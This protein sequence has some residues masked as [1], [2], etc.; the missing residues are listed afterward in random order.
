[1]PAVHWPS[2][3]SDQPFASRKVVHCLSDL[4]L[5]PAD[6]HYF[7]DPANHKDNKPPDIISNHAFFNSGANS[8]FTGVDE[9]MPAVADLVAER[10]AK[11]PKTELV[12]NEFI[13]VVQVRS[14]Q[15]GGGGSD[16]AVA[17]CL[18]AGSCWTQRLC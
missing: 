15:P 5:P 4:A 14:C 10:D 18:H 12:L 6:T 17:P 16:T 8:F 11:S 7:L 9:F 13:P 2:G 3:R 1:M